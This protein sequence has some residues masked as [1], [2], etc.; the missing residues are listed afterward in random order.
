MS[1]TI[2]SQQHENGVVV[3]AINGEITFENS[4]QL[5]E[6]IDQLCDQN[7]V[8]MIIDLVDLKYMSSAGMGVLVHGL[9]K[10]RAKGGD[11]RLIN[12]NDKMRRVFLITQFTHHFVVLKNLEEAVAS[13]AS[14]VESSR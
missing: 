3:I 4:D 7:Q 5:R 10:T 14:P 6:K 9:K 11:L 12:L 1:L 13:F 8:R 2:D